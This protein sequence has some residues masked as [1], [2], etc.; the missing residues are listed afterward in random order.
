VTSTAQTLA[1]IT[2]AALAAAGVLSWPLRPGRRLPVGPAL[3]GTPAGQETFG[4]GASGVRPVAATADGLLA[5][6]EMV[7]VQVRAGAAPALAWRTALEVLGATPAPGGERG[8]DDA[9]TNLAPEPSA[10]LR[11][12]AAP[13]AGRAPHR[14]P[15]ASCR[16]AAAAAAAGWQLAERTG[17]PLADVLDSVA[18][19]LREEASVT[20]Q[21][22]AAL[23][24]PRATA[25]LL[26][27]L[28]VAGVALGQLIGARPLSV[29]VTSGAGRTCAA[30][31]ILLML[32]GHVWM[33]RLVATVGAAA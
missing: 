26:T 30:L 23:A 2:A 20:A 15:D 27:A 8:V 22:E 16:T 7:A 3:G 13:G 33:R 17:A 19:T 25:R 11:S 14:R 4:S 6:I 18:S 5:L 29:L 1:V 21:V 9:S 12:V 10:W 28:P 24:G 31:G 32:A